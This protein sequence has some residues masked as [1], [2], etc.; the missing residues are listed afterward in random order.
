MRDGELRVVTRNRPSAHYL[1]A[2]DPQGPEFDLASRFA[3]ELGVKL[4]I[5]SVPNVGDVM[6]EL[7]SRRAHIAAA[8][9]ARGVILPR[10]TGF[11][12]PYQ[13]IKEHLIFRQGA[14]RP[15]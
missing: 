5:Y 8:G 15:R 1:G 3:A 6:R 11:G 12:P 14:A 10:D 2:S 4:Y 7:E 9:L 13:Q